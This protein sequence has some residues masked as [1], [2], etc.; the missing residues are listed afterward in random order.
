MMLPPATQRSQAYCFCN[1]AAHNAHTGDA[2]TRAD[3]AKA[4]V[5]AMILGTKRVA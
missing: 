5:E 4:D 2:K 1:P 3:A